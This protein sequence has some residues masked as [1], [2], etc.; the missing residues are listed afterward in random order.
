M[1]IRTFIDVPGRSKK[2]YVILPYTKHKKMYKS[3]AKKV[4]KVSLDF[5]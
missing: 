1:N 4:K 3:R 2:E 5:F